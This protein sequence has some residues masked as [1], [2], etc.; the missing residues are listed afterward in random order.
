M[1]ERSRCHGYAGGKG[2]GKIKY[3]PAGDRTGRNFSKGD[4]ETA[5]TSVYKRLETVNYG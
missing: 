5:I 4:V 2:A 3:F 1:R